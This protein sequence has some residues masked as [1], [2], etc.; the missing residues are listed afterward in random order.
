MSL[1]QQPGPKPTSSTALDPRPKPAGGHQ[2][3]N[4]TPV[5]KYCPCQCVYVE[6]NPEALCRRIIKP[7]SQG[8]LRKLDGFPCSKNPPCLLHLL[9]ASNNSIQILI[10]PYLTNANKPEFT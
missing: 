3:S 8:E 6:E 4:Q 9:E 1:R 2:K 7:Q 5:V 10:L